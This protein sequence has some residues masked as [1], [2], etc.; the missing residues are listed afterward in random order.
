MSG[1]KDIA[2]AARVSPSTVSNAINNRPNVSPEKREAIMKLCQEMNY[3][4][5]PAGRGL[6][7]GNSK[8]ILFVFSDFDRQFYLQII[9]GIHDFTNSKGY[10]LLICTRSSCEKYMNKQNT[11]GCIILDRRVPDEVILRY[12]TAQYPII[13]LDRIMDSPFV[14]S[15][16]INNYAAMCELMEGL[17][18]RG[19]SRFNFLS[20]V[21]TTLDSQER[22][23]AFCDTLSK[24][25]L[26]C[27][28]DSILAGDYSENSGYRAAKI[29]MLS[30]VLPEALVCANDLMAFGAIKAFESSGIAIPGDISITGFDDEQPSDSLGLTTISIPDY[31]RGYL[32]AQHLL[33]CLSGTGNFSPVTISSHVIWRN[34]TIK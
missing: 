31:E 3:Q 17:I 22:S 6:R 19:Y 33:N 8:T 29:L 26:P 1:I 23:R 15:L 10:D 24:H 14:K 12:A 2:K 4:P 9:K 32:A 11:S 27:P 28:V 16:T 13:V 5:N 30:E 18:V 7:T 25:H 21:E 20:G 34:K